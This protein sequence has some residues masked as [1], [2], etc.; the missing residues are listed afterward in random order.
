MP[1]TSDS[2]WEVRGGRR[3]RVL[4]TPL[5][6]ESHVLV[7]F[8]VAV[9]TTGDGPFPL[10]PAHGRRSPHT[11]GT[12]DLLGSSQGTHP[13]RLSVRESPVEEVNARDTSSGVPGTSTGYGCRF[14]STSHGVPVT[15]SVTGTGRVCPE[16]REVERVLFLCHDPKAQ[17]S[18]DVRLKD[19]RRDQW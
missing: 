4:T 16:T 15:G 13:K 12:P 11:H 9:V 18:Y 14:R 10:S 17:V 5:H 2:R 1:G 8:M 6:A 7:L 19:V 3:G